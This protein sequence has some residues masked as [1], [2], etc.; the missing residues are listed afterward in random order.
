[1]MTL[2]KIAGLLTVISLLTVSACLFDS[3]DD[4]QYEDR[5]E[6]KFKVI[7]SEIDQLFDNGYMRSSNTILNPFEYSEDSF[8]LVEFPEMLDSIFSAVNYPGID[9][10]FPEDGMLLIYCHQILFCEEIIEYTYSFK[11]DTVQVDLTI[12]EW[13]DGPY[14]PGIFNLV[15]PIGITL[16]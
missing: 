16:K 3:D 9:T 6:Q 12:R 5:I 1:M 7:T 13:L 11:E 8:Y 4:W 10:L 2:Q 15:F 14:D